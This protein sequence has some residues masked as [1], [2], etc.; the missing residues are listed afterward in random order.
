MPFI[1]SSKYIF[2]QNK[3]IMNDPAEVNVLLQIKEDI[4]ACYKLMECKEALIDF[5]YQVEKK[6]KTK[7]ERVLRST[8]RENRFKLMMGTS[9]RY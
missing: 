8:P 3:K 2:T 9:M 5:K 4:E 1:N 6:R 7:E